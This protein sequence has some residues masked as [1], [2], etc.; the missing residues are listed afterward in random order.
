[1]TDKKI[2]MLA[3]LGIFAGYLFLSNNLTVETVL[4]LVG[5]GI[6][7]SYFQKTEDRFIELDEAQEIALSYIKNMQNIGRFQNGEIYLYEDSGLKLTKIGSEVI[8]QK[9]IIGININSMKG[10]EIYT[11]D[12]STMGRVLG[13]CKRHRG[14]RYE[15]EEDTI[16]EKEKEGVI[17]KIKSMGSDL[18]G[19][20]S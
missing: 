14:W 13:I 2:Y 18:F 3:I 10:E 5:A 11:I 8:P 6:L 15:E 19:R 16:I 1:M 9:Y 7:L 4:L 12:I 20:K 17:E